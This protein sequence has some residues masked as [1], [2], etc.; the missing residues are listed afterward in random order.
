MEV[1]KANSKSNGFFKIFDW[2]SKTKKPKKRLFANSPTSEKS[3][4]RKDTESISRLNLEEE[5]QTTVISTVKPNTAP[6]S[7]SSSVTEEE[8][9]TKKP[10]GVVARLMGL[11]S[12]P[13]PDPLSLSPPFHPKL[14][15]SSSEPSRRM[16]VLRPGN[17]MPSSPI[18]R[19]Q[20]ESI[21]R[22]K[23]VP[24]TYYKLLSPIKNNGSFISGRNADEVMEVASRIIEKDLG[25]NLNLNLSPFRVYDSG[26]FVRG[27]PSSKPVNRRLNV[28]QNGGDLNG[29]KGK[30]RVNGSVQNQT[31]VSLP[32]TRV[33][34]PKR[35]SANPKRSSN[36]NEK[37]PVLVQNN[38]KQNSLGTRNGTQRVINGERNNNINNNN[39]S[40]GKNRVSNQLKG[41]L[42]SNTNSNRNNSRTKRL[43][44]ISEANQASTSTSNNNIKYNNNNNN[45]INNINNNNDILVKRSMRRINHNIVVERNI[46]STKKPGT[47]NNNN[48]NNNTSNNIVS[49]TFTSPVDKFHKN[50]T[51]KKDSNSSTSENN[52]NN[53]II[54]GD[55]LGV[56]L[57]QKLRELTS[58]SGSPYRK[59]PVEKD[60]NEMEISSCLTDELALTR[61]NENDGSVSSVNVDSQENERK[62]DGVNDLSPFSTLN[63]SCNSSESYESSKGGKL[64]ASIQAT[65]SLDSFRFN[66]GLEIEDEEEE[67]EFSESGSS[68]TTFTET[69]SSQNNNYKN[70]PELDFIKEILNSV[71]FSDGKIIIEINKGVFESIEDEEKDGKISKKM[72]FGC[73]YE[74]LEIKCAYFFGAGYNLWVKGDLFVNKI[75]AEGI[76]K[77]VLVE[78][79]IEEESMVDFLVD[80]DMSVDLGKWV[81]FEIEKFESG[82]EI[83]GDILGFL[84]DEL[85]GELGVKF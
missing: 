34:L 30:R 55:Y 15:A 65:K 19:F 71:T 28:G 58:G 25:L 14:D 60:R 37:K 10:P 59:S 24:I 53:N 83:E 13:K 54:D 68:I 73:V 26:R 4:D 56:L 75:S 48:N 32:Q 3:A 64:C 45:N 57:E 38:R 52:N 50:V 21:K 44:T 62:C 49:F 72:L 74:Y 63:G 22:G 85:V 78:K 79:G 7:C 66:E 29:D 9:T 69:A 81:D 77:E 76:F 11:D 16:V 18:E 31:R 47:N 61:E 70:T 46:S 6:T 51:T 42:N 36:S 20:T 43:S 40:F 84:I 35:E 39:A 82:S 80:R 17:K 27:N 12:L 33:N 41:N 2:G 23:M 67:T 1:E 5:D 8:P